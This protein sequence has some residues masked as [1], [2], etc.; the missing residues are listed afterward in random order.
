MKPEAHYINGELKRLLIDWY[1]SGIK[2]ILRHHKNGIEN[3]IRKEWDVNGKLT[4]QANFVDGVE[5]IK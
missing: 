5:E 3:G 2:L 4:L 1:E